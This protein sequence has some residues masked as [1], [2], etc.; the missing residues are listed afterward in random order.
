MSNG[1]CDVPGCKKAALVCWRPLTES[2][3]W[4][5]CRTHFQRH[6]VDGSLYDHFNIERPLPKPVIR[7]PKPEPVKSLANHCSCG[8]EMPQGHTFCKGCLAKREKARKRKAYLKRKAE[9]KLYCE[10]GKERQS[11]HKF[12][13]KCAARKDKAQHSKRQRD[14]YKKHK[15]AMTDGFVKNGSL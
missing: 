10:C 12:C 1:F 6:K 4:Q 9:K 14:Y 8:K 11:G 5:I 7:K 15:M 2:I 13:L 3:G